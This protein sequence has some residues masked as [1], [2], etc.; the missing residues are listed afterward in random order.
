G[1]G[2]SVVDWVMKTE[3]VAFRH[4]V[5]LLREGVDMSGPI[6]PKVATVPKLPSP[7]SADVDDAQLLAQVRDYYHSTMKA[8]AE[9]WSYLEKRGLKSQ[10]LVEHFK[11]GFSNRTLGL[12]LPD[13]N[14]EAGATIRTRLQ[15][16]GVMR[17]SGHE[18]FVGSLV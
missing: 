7:V 2:G 3:G 17:E 9:A 11:L 5:E 4:A 10:E 12:R 15:K 8:S 13:K 18:H 16:L 14:R 1:S 6:G